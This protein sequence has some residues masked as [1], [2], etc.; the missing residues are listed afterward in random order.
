MV[1]APEGVWPA[2]TAAS[3]QMWGASS[4]HLQLRRLLGATV[5]CQSTCIHDF[6]IGRTTCQ[7]A[8]TD[9]AAQ[10]LCRQGQTEVEAAH[11][12]AAEAWLG[13]CG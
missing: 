6:S 5:Q 9:Q 10:G 1:W 3:C 8:V 2:A 4:S 12:R 7:A 13:A 11:L